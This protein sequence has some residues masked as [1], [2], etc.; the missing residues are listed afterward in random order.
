[1]EDEDEHVEAEP[2]EVEQVF[3]DQ[4]IAPG[5]HELLA[6]GE[7]VA[8]ALFARHEVEVEVRDLVGRP[9]RVGAAEKGGD[10]GVIGGA[11]VGEAGDRRARCIGRA[12]VSRHQRC[13]ASS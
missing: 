12:G 1:V 10:Y 4:R 8:V 5:P 7:E 6:P 3:Q 2:L 9:S 11:A 13:A